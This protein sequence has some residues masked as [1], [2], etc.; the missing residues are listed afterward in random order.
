[1]L[2]EKLVLEKLATI[3]DALSQKPVSQIVSDIAIR[4]D[5]AY[6][7]LPCN[8]SDTQQY[9]ELKKKIEELFVRDGIKVKISLS[10]PLANQNKIQ[11]IS[12]VKKVIMVASGKGGVGKS[13]VAF[14][15]AISLA[16]KGFKVGIVD[17]DIYGPSMPRLS[18][19]SKKP[20][21]DNNMMIPHYKYG[22]S[23]MSVGYLVDGADALIWRGPMT[24][25][26]LYQ[27]IRLTNWSAHDTEGLD[28][29]IIDTPPGTGDVQLS[30]MENYPIE[31]AI[32]VSTPQGMAI[33]D[34]SKSIN[35]LE[36]MNI[37]I[38]GIVQNYSYLEDKSGHKSYL[39]GSNK[40]NVELAKKHRTKILAE[41]P[42]SQEV[43]NSCDDG[44]P[45]SYYQ[46]NNECS[47]MFESIA[48]AVT[49]AV[50]LRA[51]ALK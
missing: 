32:V 4:H 18:G 41:L 24:T 25:K 5:C 14:N 47:K 51:T 26:M 44:K 15:L 21:L 3:Q 30:L 11:P 37:P 13:T 7:S 33:A 27:L 49:A 35:M 10:N 31:G 22:I 1:M 6:F 17:V 16:K 2:N 36:K 42:I 48:S 50:A 20:A 39:F 43:S 8:P 45:I 23:M 38:I 34:V 28:Y 40:R 46:E 9:E 19:I 29:L 12:G